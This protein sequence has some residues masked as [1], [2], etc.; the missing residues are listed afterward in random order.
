VVAGPTLLGNISGAIVG[1][2]IA[3]PVAGVEW[4]VGRKRQTVAVVTLLVPIYL[5]GGIVGTPF[6][7]FAMALPEDRWVLG[8][9]S[10]VAKSSRVIVRV[11][12]AA[13]RA[14]KAASEAEQ[15]SRRA[16]EAA[17]YA[18]ELLEQLMRQLRNAEP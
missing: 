6:L 8:P 3:L 18:E 16:D 14:E 7:P 17:Q 10:D 5:G 1:A 2:L 15:S 9:G 12:E 4:L 11:D 13:S